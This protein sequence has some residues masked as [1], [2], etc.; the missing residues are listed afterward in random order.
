M[1]LPGT[2]NIVNNDLPT[3]Q[4]LAQYK[5]FKHKQRAAEAEG[6]ADNIKNGSPNGK[7]R[8]G[9]RNINNNNANDKSNDGDAN[10]AEPDSSFT[11]AQDAALIKLKIKDTSWKA[12]AT[13]LGKEVGQVQQRFD[14]IK[15]VDYDKRHQEAQKAKREEKQKQKQKGGDGGVEGNDSQKQEQEQGQGGAANES[16]GGK[17]AKRNKGRGAAAAAKEEEEEVEE[18]D[19]DEWWEQP[20]DNWSKAEVSDSQF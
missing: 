15:P 7:T 6:P 13:E 9:K 4:F 5:T 2:I 10:D 14:D 16:G 20:D 17:K 8:I 3:V 11:E 18:E 12:I 1:R 19:G